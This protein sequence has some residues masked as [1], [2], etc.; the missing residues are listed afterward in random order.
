LKKK[1]SPS[2]AI[3]L[4]KRDA[5]NAFANV[6]QRHGFVWVDCSDNYFIFNFNARCDGN[7]TSSTRRSLAADWSAHKLPKSGNLAES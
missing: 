4:R 1:Q 3:M 6:I 2:P 7:R 5:E